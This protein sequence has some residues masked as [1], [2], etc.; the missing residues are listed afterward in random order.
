[1]NDEQTIKIGDKAAA[2]VRDLLA[3]ARSIDEQLG[4][5]LRGLGL[6]LSV[7]DDWRF[8][9]RL[10]AFV[11]PPA[12][13]QPPAPETQTDQKD[14]RFGDAGRSRQPGRCSAGCDSGS[15]AAFMV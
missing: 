11:P 9:P 2:Q 5:F 13:P 8:D 7:P 12:Q 4:A 14:H 10:M 3:E 1:M 6:G 15:A